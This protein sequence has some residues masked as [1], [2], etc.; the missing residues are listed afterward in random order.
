[1]SK[2]KQYVLGFMFSQD[3]RTVVLI[4]KQRP[5]WQKGK[6]NGVGGLVEDEVLRDAMA[7]EFAEETGVKTD[8]DMWTMF[9]RMKFKDHDVFCFAIRGNPNAARTRTDEKVEVWHIGLVLD[10]RHYCFDP[11]TIGNHQPLMSLILLAEYSLNNSLP[12]QPFTT[13]DYLRMAVVPVKR[14]S[15]VAVES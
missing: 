8:P 10:R 9:A 5:A 6:W 14:E 2:R 7:R 1:M 12:A 15:F 4:E 3:L 13:I 11:K